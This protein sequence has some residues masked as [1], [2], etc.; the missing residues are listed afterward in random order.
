VRTRLP[1]LL[2]LT[3]LVL[4]ATGCGSAGFRRSW[5]AFDPATAGGMVGRWTG[6]WESTWNGHAGGLRAVITARDERHVLARFLS[7]YAS[8]LSFGHDALFHV[9]AEGEARWRFAGEQDLGKA[10]G[11]VYRYEGTVEGDRFEAT[12]AAENGDHGV[13]RMRRV[14]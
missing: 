13:F 5:D 12:Y 2:A 1:S 14:D 8:V 10:F 9:D 7:T 3:V 6:D 4:A 11:G